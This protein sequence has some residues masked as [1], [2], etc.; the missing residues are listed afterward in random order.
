MAANAELIQALRDAVAASPD[1]ISLRKHLADL[2]MESEAYAEAAKIYRQ[3]L[4]AA[5]EDQDVKLALA[6]AYAKQGQVEV[7]LVVV[8]QLMR[9][10]TPPPQAFLLAAGYYLETGELAQAARAYREAIGRDPTLEDS[11]LAAQVTVAPLVAQDSAEEVAPA[12]SADDIQVSDDLVFVTAE[13]KPGPPSTDVECPTLTFRD[14]GGMEQLKE[15]I[16]M[17][18]IYPLTHPELYQAYGKSSGG[19]ILMYGP[20]GCGKTYLARATA[21]EVR[22][23]FM[24]IGLH[25]VLDV[26]LGQSEQNLHQVFELARQSAPCVLFFDE[27]DALG[28]KRSDMRHS[29]IRQVINQFLMEMDNVTTSNEGVLILAATNAPWH[30]DSALRRPG[31]FDRVLFVPP[32]DLPA[33]VAILQLMLANKPTQRLNY[34][35]LARET[36][37]FSGADLRGVIEQ[38]VEDKLREA[39]RSG[40]PHPLTTRDLLAVI[41]TVRPTTKEWFE[42]ARNYALYSNQSGAYDDILEYLNLSGQSGLRP[43]RFGGG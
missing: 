42:T 40:R 9:S 10:A 43:P 19:G 4:D 6:K 37:G 14:V 12:T 3:V 30:L 23:S 41:K 32:P 24:A 27:V 2:L 31:R 13:D 18:I 5:P 36:Q 25:D 8:E 22:A 21:G 33:R 16:R 39:M 38:A 17:K 15:E 34:E 11:A 28:A 7:A 35:K 1:K 26:F 29:A 20:P